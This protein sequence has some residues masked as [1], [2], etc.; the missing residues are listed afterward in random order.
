MNG[1]PW[2]KSGSDLAE[3]ALEALSVL[4]RTNAVTCGNFYSTR[5]R[6]GSYLVRDE[7]VVD[8]DSPPTT[9]NAWPDYERASDFLDELSHDVVEDLLEL[10]EESS[11]ERVSAPALPAS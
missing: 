9:A 5:S 8:S 6:P 2:E 3:R 4:T 7:E 10:R 1:P 11:E